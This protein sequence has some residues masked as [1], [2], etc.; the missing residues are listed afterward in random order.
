MND[1]EEAKDTVKYV[2]GRLWQNAMYIKDELKQ[3]ENEKQQ[4]FLE[5]VLHGYWEV[6]DT[7]TNE[8]DLQDVDP[9]DIGFYYDLKELDYTPKALAV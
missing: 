7:L 8:V 4:K 2:I 6:F 1:L 5:G 9:D 3:C